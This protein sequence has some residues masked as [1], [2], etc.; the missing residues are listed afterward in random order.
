MKHIEENFLPENLFQAARASFPTHFWSYWVRYPYGKLASIGHDRIPPACRL[1]LDYMATNFP[2]PIPNAFPDMTLYGAGLSS[3]PADTGIGW[4]FD[5]EVH[6]TKKWR[7]VGSLVLFLNEPLGGDLLL[8]EP[9]STVHEGT[10]D[11]IQPVKN[12]AVFFGADMPHMVDKVIGFSRKTLSLFFWI[13]DPHIL[14]G[15]TSPKFLP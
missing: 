8:H 3:I 9:E 1:A 12:R 14:D 5:A 10:A 2:V 4:H 13:E 6:G 15:S 11:R 7:R